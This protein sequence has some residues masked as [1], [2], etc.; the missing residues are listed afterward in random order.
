MGILYPPPSQGFI[1]SCIYATHYPTYKLLLS[2]IKSYTYT[3]K[4]WSVAGSGDPPLGVE[5]RDLLCSDGRDGRG[6]AEGRAVH[7]NRRHHTQHGHAQQDR[8]CAHDRDHAQV[9]SPGLFTIY[10]SLSQAVFLRAYLGQPYVPPYAN[11]LSVIVR[12]ALYNNRIIET[13]HGM[14]PWILHRVTPITLCNNHI[15]KP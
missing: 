8:D 7:T 4:L 13:H 3:D 12:I 11:A 9:C 15:V 5:R 6:P 2:H 10:A 14:Q 1:T